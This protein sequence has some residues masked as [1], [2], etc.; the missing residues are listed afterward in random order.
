M[1]NLAFNLKQLFSMIFP[2]LR[3]KS[4]CW[5][6]V[7][8]FALRQLQEYK[9]F[10]GLPADKQQ[11]AAFDALWQKDPV[12]VTAIGPEKLLQSLPHLLSLLPAVAVPG[13][14]LATKD[15]KPKTTEA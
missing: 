7:V 3:S 1:M 5:I 12:F 2:F 14:E 4:I 11:Q 10:T 15:D 8:L 13:A 6:T 9:S